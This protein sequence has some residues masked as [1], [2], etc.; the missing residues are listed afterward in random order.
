MEI[1]IGL[2]SRVG[3]A[4]ATPT[5]CSQAALQLTATKSW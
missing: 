1:V 4:E 5:S 3:S 2:D